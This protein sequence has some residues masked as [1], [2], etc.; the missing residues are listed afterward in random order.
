MNK[1][2]NAFRFAQQSREANVVEMCKKDTRD[3]I[4]E[5]SE[6]PRKERDLLSLKWKYDEWQP[7]NKMDNKG[8]KGHD[9]KRKTNLII[10]IIIPLVFLLLFPSFTISL[11]DSL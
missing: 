9:I 5:V 8:Q 4:V 11:Y 6:G 10:I 2:K 3:M 1:Q 7:I